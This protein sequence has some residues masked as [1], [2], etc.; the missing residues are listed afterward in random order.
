MRKKIKHS[1]VFALIVAFLLFCNQDDISESGLTSNNPNLVIEEASL[2][3]SKGL[4]RSAPNS[5]LSVSGS[6]T[7]KIKKNINEIP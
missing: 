2:N 7:K 4:N 5:K 3:I 1:I 6:E